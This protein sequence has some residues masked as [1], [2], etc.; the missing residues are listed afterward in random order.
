MVSV[1]QRISKIKQPRG[2]Y[3]KPKNFDVIELND[4]IVLYEEENIHSALTG[5]AVDY[6][7]RFTMGT[8]LEKAFRISLIGASRVNEDNYAEE[9]L[10]GINGLDDNSIENACKL[11]GFDT[12]HRAGIASYKPVHTIQPDLAT[13]SNIRNMVK[14]SMT[15]ND[16]FG[17]IVK[18]GFTFEGGYTQ[19]IS[20]GD[21][22][23]LTETT[24]WDFKVSKKNPTNKNTLQLLIYYLMGVHSIHSEF[25]QIEKLG[26]F[27]PRLNKVYLLAIS[28]ISNEIINEVKTT[29]IGY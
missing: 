23:F 8:S 5:L 15:F 29:V 28:A 14:R 25:E 3:I 19:F 2:G 16:N 17:P 4:G 10:S 1:T 26:I 11:V 27:N 7:T 24:L 13:I 18:D 12:A 22:D 20:S 6:L 21:G 9:L